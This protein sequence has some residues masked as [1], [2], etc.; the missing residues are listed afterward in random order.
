MHIRNK[1]MLGFFPTLF[2][3]TKEIRIKI[4]MNFEVMVPEHQAL[5]Y[6]QANFI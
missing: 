6:V 4:I 5:T 2:S 1:K 3:T